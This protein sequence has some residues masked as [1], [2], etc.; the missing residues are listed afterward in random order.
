MTNETAIEASAQRIVSVSD[1]TLLW[2][3]AGKIFADQPRTAE[4]AI[5]QAGL[6][7]DVELRTLGYHNENGNF[8]VAPS[9]FATVRTDTDALLG[10]VKSRY[11]VFTNRQAFQFADNL[12]DGAGASFESG[13][14]SHGGKVVG[15]TMKLPTT[16]K[17]DG[18]DVFD[19]YLML[20]TTHDGSGSIQVAINTVRMAC[21]N[22]FDGELRRAKQKFSFRHTAAAD[23]QIA[24]ARETL[25]LSFTYAEEFE[26]EMERLMNTPVSNESRNTL[27]QILVD[28]RV[29]EKQVEAQV[30]D[31]FA[32][33][34]L[35]STIPDTHRNDGYGLLN[36]TTEYYQHL[37]TYRTDQSRFLGNTEGLGH[38]VAGQLE[39]ELVLA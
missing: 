21:L 17:V 31:I 35:S 33:L 38:K 5:T 20:R 3:R 11:K 39:K 27:T 8:K 32:N 28:N 18:E 4:E 19:Q 36:A 16:V 34:A 10:T 6:G 37:K 9:N 25:A 12:V 22:M 13:F 14:E 24:Q 29:S 23:G 7:W 30:N 15:L 1:R 26:K 2:G